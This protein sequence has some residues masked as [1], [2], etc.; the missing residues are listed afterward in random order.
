MQGPVLA[1][2]PP[3]GDPTPADQEWRELA[4]ELAPAK[5]LQRLDAAATRVVSTVSLVATLLTGLGLIAAGL[6]NLTAFARWLAIGA[7]ALAF[8]AALEALRAQTLGI[9]RGLNRENLAEV[10][11]WYLERFEKR[12]PRL[13]R[14]TYL[15]VGAAA[16]AGAAAV[17]TLLCGTD[18]PTLA[19]TRTS[20]PTPGKLTVDVTFRGL[21]DG[22]TLSA[23]VRVDGAVAAE[24]IVGPGPDG[25]ASRT[26]A[27]EQVPASG[28]VAVEARGGGKTC[29]AT[30]TPGAAAEVRCPG[31]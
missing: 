6:T 22:E 4:A 2:N 11:D 27:V 26:L 31:G 13:R 16:L 29:T 30:L 5:S 19:V 23:V 12:A 9:I 25:T 18:P 8:L 15:L 1:V 7:V 24:A 10:E 17:V 3:V 14:A 20:V 28:V 21:D